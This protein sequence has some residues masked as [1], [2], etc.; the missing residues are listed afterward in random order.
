MTEFD[1]NAYTPFASNWFIVA[2]RRD[3]MSASIVGQAARNALL[4]LRLVL[5]RLVGP[6]VGLVLAMTTVN[7]WPNSGPPVLIGLDA[8]FSWPGSTSAQAIEKGILIAV[9][10]IN[11]RGGVLGGRPLQLIKKDNGT[12]P[13]RSI[14]NLRNLAETPELVAAFCG[15]FSPTVIEAM[16][17]VH[18]L[19]L[20]LLDPWAA[21]DIIT[22]NTYSPSYAFRLSLRDSY[23]MPSLL[24][25]GR[26]Q[27][28]RTFGMMALNTTWGRS[29]LRAAEN[30][31]T[32][33][34]DTKLAGTRWF[35]WQDE[36]LLDK[37]LDLKRLGA[38]AILLVANDREASILLK[39]MAALPK[40]ERVPVLSH[41]GVSGG[42]MN[43]T[44]GTALQE[45]NFVMVQTYSFIGDRRP[46]AR[47]VVAAANRLFG[48]PNARAIES[49]VGLAHAYDLTHLLARAIDR[50]G[51]S[52]RATVRQALEE[53]PEYDGLIKRYRRPFSKGRHD[54]LTEADVIITRYAP[55]GAIV[56]VTGA[57]Q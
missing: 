42:Q 8:E 33:Y 1:L 16:E 31:L 2:L 51:T 14:R 27:G 40:S 13:A 17:T 11:R 24:R 28:I 26:N 38:Q 41:W 47:Q 56:P 36:S 29:N 44:A 4:I 18:T 45:V 37:Y 35:N 22:D 5:G 52:D 34:P 54:A 55:D 20:I 30:Y 43:E 19:K 53:L 6:V 3:R 7:A 57:R 10:E 50:A 32:K 23:A 21:A 49:P 12:V 15:R 9:D 39:E 48:I 46:R 25:Y